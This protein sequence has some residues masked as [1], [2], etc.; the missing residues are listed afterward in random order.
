MELLREDA[1]EQ[2]VS[3]RDLGI[4]DERTQRR[5]DNEYE[6]PMSLLYPKH[7]RGVLALDDFE[8]DE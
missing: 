6:T 3:L 1:R 2:G 7:R 4:L 5:I 8:E